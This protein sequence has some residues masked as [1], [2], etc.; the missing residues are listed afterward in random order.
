L[1]SYQ[2]ISKKRGFL[3]LA[4]TLIIGYEVEQTPEENVTEYY[5]NGG[6]IER[7]VVRETLNRLG[8][9]IEGVNA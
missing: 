9:K 8:I 6:H 4:Q 5:K 2:T 7:I 1:K 3:L